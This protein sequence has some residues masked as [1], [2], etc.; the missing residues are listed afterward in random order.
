M[1][2]RALAKRGVALELVSG[3][4]KAALL[5]A[6]ERIS[7]TVSEEADPIWFLHFENYNTWATAR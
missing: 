2:E 4:S 3:A 7:N 1:R 6:R 5:K